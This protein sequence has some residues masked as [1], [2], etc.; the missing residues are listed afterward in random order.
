[1][2]KKFRIK[3]IK[4]GSSN[5]SNYQQYG[6]LCVKSLTYGILTDNQLEAVRRCILRSIKRKGI[7]WIRIQCTYPVT[8]KSVGSR[9][10][11]GVGAVKMYISNVKKGSILLELQAPISREL[12][13][14]LKK[15]ASKLS[16]KIAI[17]IRSY[18]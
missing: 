4:K 11:K 15:V 18:Y 8:K 3:N 16:V 9:M 17:F 12:L 6:I 14:L 13:F 7:I 1:M 5:F 2:K 10:G